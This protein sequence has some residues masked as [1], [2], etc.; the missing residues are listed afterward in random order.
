[1]RSRSCSAAGPARRCASASAM[2]I[3]ASGERSS[4]DTSRSSVS[5]AVTS[6]WMR[7]AIASK[8][9]ASVPTS[10][11]RR[12]NGRPD[13]SLEVAGRD[14]AA[15]FLQPHDRRREIAREQHRHDGRGQDGDAEHGHLR[16]GPHQDA[17]HRD[18]RAR[19]QQAVLL[20]V[21]GRSKMCGVSCIGRRFGGGLGRR[22][23]RVASSRASSRGIARPS[24]SSPRSFVTSSTVP[25]RRA[26]MVEQPGLELA[27]AAVGERVRPLPR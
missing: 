24:S 6:A 2:R 22:Y 26:R 19:E 3:L 12:S 1:M 25:G 11:L 8:S 17:E 27:L 13:A 4:C 23:G 21:A 16:A 18:R 15:G 20:V 5:F 14:R 9:R 10:S 7:S